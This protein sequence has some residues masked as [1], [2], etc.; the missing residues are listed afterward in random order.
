MDFDTARAAIDMLF[1]ESGERRGVHI[2]FF[3]GETLMNFPLLE[4]VVEYAN[5]QAAALGR[6]IDFSLTTNATLLTPAIIQFLSANRRVTVSMDGRRVARRVA[7]V[8]Q[9]AAATISSRPRCGNCWRRLHAR[10]RRV[11]R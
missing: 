4:R 11:S 9:T 6:S 2:T 8:R 5:L 10:S 1:A 7:C 3:G